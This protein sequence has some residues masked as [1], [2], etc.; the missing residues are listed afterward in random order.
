MRLRKHKNHE[1]KIVLDRDRQ[2]KDWHKYMIDY[3]VRNESNFID[4]LNQQQEAA[5]N[6]MIEMQNRYAEAMS[7]M[8]EYNEFV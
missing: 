1:K 5:I 3:K 7:G 6:R 4:E 2:M 8:F